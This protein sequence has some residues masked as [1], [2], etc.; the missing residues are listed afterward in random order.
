MSSLTSLKHSQ[1]LSWP[2]QLVTRDEQHFEC[3]KPLK[4]KAKRIVCLIRFQPKGEETGDCY[5]VLKLFLE[6]QAE[7]LMQRELRGIKA[8][9]QHFI[10]PKLLAQGSLKELSQARF[11]VYE[12]LG[13]PNALHTPASPEQW[14][15]KQLQQMVAYIAK[16]HNH[17]LSHKDTQP[18]NFCFFR[19]NLYL[20]DFEAICIHAKSPSK[21]WRLKNLAS[22]LAR[23]PKL[24]SFTQIKVLHEIYQT[25][26]QF[27]AIT[28]KQLL[29]AITTRLQSKVRRT[30]KKSILPFDGR[31]VKCRQGYHV[32]FYRDCMNDAM[33]KMLQDIDTVVNN[34]PSL[35]AG[36]ISTVV[37]VTVA[38]KEWVIK[39]S[40]WK[41]WQGWLSR[42]CWGSRAL[43]YW[44]VTHALKMLG[45]TLPTPCALLHKRRYGLPS[46][47]YMIYEYIDGISLHDYARTAT[48][49]ETTTVA[50]NLVTLLTDT[51][52]AGIVNGDCKATNF[53]V[54]GTDIFPID[55]ESYK[56]YHR[57]RVLRR[58]WSSSLDRFMSN[59]HTPDSSGG[60]PA[61]SLKAIFTQQFKE[62]GTDQLHLYGT[63]LDYW[64][65]IPWY[66]RIF[67]S[68]SKRLPEQK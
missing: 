8:L 53:V 58:K 50:E 18:D 41:N 3:L 37:R 21:G 67:G 12:Y 54:L 39:R 11:I 19:E 62:L 44:R 17:K 35:K 42:L 1:N 60:T 40:H 34:A 63:H 59:W 36:S 10:T 47:S 64:F 68:Y 65:K 5:G 30:M 51:M 2:F 23:Q 57:Y 49:E 29:Q 4:I 52:R 22:F 66:H 32:L 7:K 48:P 61:T 38:G 13:D 28:L 43:K 55:L 33:E 24:L 16:L 26:T 27:E 31:E 20:L 56:M 14:S 15:I 25:H 9:Q 46:A 45:M 6:P